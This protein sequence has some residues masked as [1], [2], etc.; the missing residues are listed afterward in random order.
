[1]AARGDD[2]CGD[3][4]LTEFLERLQ[5][6]LSADEIVSRTVGALTFGN[7]DR[8][9]QSKLRDVLYDFLEGLPIA[10]TRVHNGDAVDRDQLGCLELGVRHHATSRTETWTAMSNKRSSV[11]KR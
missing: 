6:P 9:L 3:L 7:R 11:S 5:P 10:D 2:D 4:G 1:F 8:T